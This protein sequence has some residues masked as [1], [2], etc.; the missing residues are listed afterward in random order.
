MKIDVDRL[1]IKNKDI[2]LYGAGGKTGRS[3]AEF[4]SS[5]GCRLYLYDDRDLSELEDTL[6]SYNMDE[7]KISWIEKKKDLLQA[8]VIITSPGVSLHREIFRQAERQGISI[9]SEIELAY[10]F[11]D[12]YLIAITGTN[13]KTTTVSLAGQMLNRGLESREVVT[14]GNIGKPLLEAMAESS[15]DAIMVVEVSSFQLA[16]IENFRPEIAALLNFAPDHLDW[17][18]NLQNYRRAK[19]N[20]FTNQSEDDMAL[21]DID[22]EKTIEMAE[23]SQAQIVKIG[24]SADKSDILVDG[25][26]FARSGEAN[27]DKKKLVEGSSAKM[28]GGHN[29][30]NI[31]FAAAI[32]REME[33]DSKVIREVICDFSPP[34][35]RM[36]EVYRD[37]NILIIDDSK[38]TNPHAACSALSSLPQDLHKVIIA[39]GQDR[40]VNLNSLAA[41][42]SSR[43]SGAVLLGE[44]ADKLESKLEDYGFQNCSKVND[45]KQAVKESLEMTGGE[46]IIILSPGAPSWDMYKSYK[47]RGSIFQKYAGKFLGVEI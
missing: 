43:V 42:I 18:K 10:N 3:V 36:Q 5:L 2:A 45:M 30:K 35:H 39:G 4:L 22:S 44:I 28:I 1:S 25:D 29:L 21:I 38:A 7:G 27:S 17:H 47:E 20:I 40:G 16:A 31:A 41:E 14:A 6:R 8:E 34:P 19:Q 33:V 23:T 32:A 15:A 9:L 12:R 26:I 11:F 37:D 13:G 46:G 24:T